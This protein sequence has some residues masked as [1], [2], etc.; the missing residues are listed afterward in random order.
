MSISEIYNAL[1]GQG[2]TVTKKTIER[3]L[4]EVSNNF[5]LLETGT[6]PM[7]F[8]A[9]VDFCPDYE[10]L[11][12]ES[13]LQVILLAL[14]NLKQTSPKYLQGLCASAETSLE[15]KLPKSLASDLATYK[16]L[17]LFSYGING[18]AV[19]KDN[20]SF[21]LIMK[22]LR[23][24]KAFTAH[25]ISPYKDD[26]YNSRQRNF[27]PLLF[28]MSGGIPYLVVRDL[29]DGEKIKSLRMTRLVNAKLTCTDVAPI[30]SAER[31]QVDHIFGGYIRNIDEVLNYEI[32]GDEVL[33]T[34]FGEREIHNTQKI[35]GL[36]G[37]NFR[38]SFS[39]VQSNEIDKIL[40]GLMDHIDS[41]SPEEV[42]HNVKKK[43]A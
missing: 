25:N 32:I 39:A 33:A 41:I 40:A 16:D 20:E 21:G 26:E 13:E 22:C 11:L 42:F 24:G 23:Q 18:R 12:S 37:G 31:L 4:V 9:S 7:R 10:L 1:I 17:H 43:V 30:T 15:S 27:A 38:V 14:D 19:A 3:D 28:H 2:V 8:Y 35:E 29:D 6:Y 36:G 34:Y 5:K